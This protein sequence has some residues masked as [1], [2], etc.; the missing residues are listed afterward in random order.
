MCTHSFIYYKYI[1]DK[2]VPKMFYFFFGL[3]HAY[4][5]SHDC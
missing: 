5:F 4:Y 1:Q 2:C 3:S